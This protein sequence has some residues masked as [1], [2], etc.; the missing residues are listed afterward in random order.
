MQNLIKTSISLQ[1]ETDR[2]AKEL[3]DAG[4]LGYPTSKASVIRYCLDRGLT[5]QEYHTQFFGGKN[6]QQKQA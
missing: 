5:I 1:P 2:L 6:V 4:A 3:A